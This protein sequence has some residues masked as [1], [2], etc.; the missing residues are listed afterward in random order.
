VDDHP[1]IRKGLTATL[2]PEAGMEV[3]TSAGTQQALELLRQHQ[4]DITLMDLGLEGERGGIEA[5]QQIRAE[6]PLAK[7]IA[8]SALQG[9]EDVYRA[10]HSGAVTFLSK[11]T[12][13][14]TLVQAV[15]EVHAG[16]R[17]IP[18]DVAR[19]LADR[20]TLSSLTPR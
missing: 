2:E 19:R 16:G 10:I 9:D 4:R 1:A 17:P 18:Q 3:V 7:I 15:R 6:F 20:L 12:P 13:D 14:E 5:I 8:F 11:E